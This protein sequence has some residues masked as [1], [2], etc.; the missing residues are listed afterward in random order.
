[1][2]DAI[3]HRPGP[4]VT[5]LLAKPV[6]GAIPGKRARHQALDRVELPDE[7]ANL[8]AGRRPLW[9]DVIDV[10]EDTRSVAVSVDSVASAAAR[11]EV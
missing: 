7:R 2:P 1:V 4:L 3:E 8:G 10:A 9:G 6:R 11:W 5:E